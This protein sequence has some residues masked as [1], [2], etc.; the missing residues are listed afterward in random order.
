MNVQVFF[1]PVDMKMFAMC[2][3]M[4]GGIMAKCVFCSRL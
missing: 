3:K 1:M 4:L 2:K